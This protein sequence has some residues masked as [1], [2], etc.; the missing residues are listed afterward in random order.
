MNTTFLKSQVEKAHDII[1]NS[2]R[3]RFFKVLNNVMFQ[4]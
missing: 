3:R 1:K 4:Y 2:Y